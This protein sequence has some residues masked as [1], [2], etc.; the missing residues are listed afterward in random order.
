VVSVS[1]PAVVAPRGMVAAAHPLASLA[2]MRMLIAGGNAVDAAVAV[3]AT[4]NVVEPYMS[5]LAGDGYMVISLAHSGQR[6]A[7]DY[8]GRTAQAATLDRYT[9][10][11]MGTGALA[12]LVPGN[13]GGWLHA[14]DR[15]GTMRR[16]DVFA[17]AIEYAEGG[18]PLSRTNVAF[19]APQRDRLNPAGRAVFFPGGRA[20]QFGE[21]IYQRDLAQTYRQIVDGGA[22]VLYRGA[23]GRKIVSFLQEQGGVLSGEDLASF[24]VAE[25]PRISTTFRGFE[26]TTLPPPCA[27]VQYLETLKLLEGFDLVAMGL[28]SAQLIHHV[29]EA[30]KI[31]VADRRDC[32]V[33]GR[34]P[35]VTAILDP[36]YLARRRAEINP[37]RAAISGGDRFVGV[38]LPGEIS[39]GVFPGSNAEQTTSFSVVD[40]AGNAVTVTQS[41]GQGFGSGLMVDGTGVFLNDFSW[42]LDLDP[43]S[44][45]CLGPA[46]K[47]EMC[48]APCQIFRDGQLYLTIGTPGGWGIPQTT[49]QMILNVMEFGLD[50]QEA[51]D[52][53]RFRCAV[54]VTEAPGIVT[55]LASLP[56]DSGRELLVEGRIAA[57]VLA[58][59]AT[60]GHAVQTLPE[61]T[62]AVGGGHGIK[63]DPV[64]G[65]RIGGADPRRDGVVIG[66]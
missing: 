47:I 56:P 1:R 65:A 51:I 26:V 54:Q 49:T 66:F 59:L 19:I 20:P 34:E 29:A 30:I 24:Q 55:D 13:L 61:W 17:P 57:E 6:I 22:D 28:G 11:T 48:M 39:A 60:Y 42:W 10:Q 3:A 32:Y 50:T 4:L 18:F 21:V 8:V 52:A 9:P 41:L 43:A 16:S 36:G 31:A 53:P 5:G 7:L 37:R 45:N 63:V 33:G 40:A 14:L 15:Y 46:K 64:S 38:R 23:L 2:G 12:P 35:P 58:E 62:P 27:G 44:P 25:V